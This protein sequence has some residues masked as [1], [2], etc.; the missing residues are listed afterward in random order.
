MQGIRNKHPFLFLWVLVMTQLLSLNMVYH[1]CLSCIVLRPNF[2]CFLLLFCLLYI[3][4]ELYD[5]FCI[6]SKLNLFSM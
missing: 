4:A 2:A 3:Y 5:Q 6:H 1:V